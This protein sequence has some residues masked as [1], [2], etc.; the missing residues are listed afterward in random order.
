MVTDRNDF[1]LIKGA[2][3]SG[4]NNEDLTGVTANECAALC[5]SRTTFTC[6]SFDHNPSTKE[7]WL[8]EENDLTQSFRSDASYN[9]FVRTCEFNY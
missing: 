4:Y 1:A 6:R 3:I 8:S 7:C 5:V 2:A 9:L